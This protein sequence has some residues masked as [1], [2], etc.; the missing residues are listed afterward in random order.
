[1]ATKL[2]LSDTTVQ[3][4]L[5]QKSIIWSSDQFPEGWALARCFVQFLPLRA[6]RKSYF[7]S[8]RNESSSF[9][10]SLPILLFHRGNR[11]S[12]HSLGFPCKHSKFWPLRQSTGLPSFWE[13]VY[14]G[15]Y[16]KARA[17]HT[18]TSL[19]LAWHR[20]RF[21]GFRMESLRWDLLLPSTPPAIL[22]AFQHLKAVSLSYIVQVT[23]NLPTLPRLPWAAT[24]PE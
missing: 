8:R 19:T 21:Q 4:P 6:S 18:S 17:I 2:N 5:Q 16:S 11:S 7:L 23:G 24:R 15:H 22:P 12:S 1:M 14:T 9:Q 20:L 3:V 10:W 13:C